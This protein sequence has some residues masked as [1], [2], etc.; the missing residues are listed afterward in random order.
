MSRIFLS[1]RSTDKAWARELK[2]LLE[3]SGHV[4]VFVDDD[5]ETGIPYGQDWERE[6]YR[7]VVNCRAVVILHSKGW[8]ESK[9]CFAE[10]TQARALGKFIIPLRLDDHPLDAL[11]SDTQAIPMT[12]GIAPKFPLLERSLRM[13][14]ID[15][16]DSF[17]WKG[18]RDPYPGLVA[19]E[20]EDA[21]VF[22][23]RDTEI[24]NTL[25]LLSRVRRRGGGALAMVLGASGSGKSSLIRAGVVPR[26]RR[27]TDHWIVTSPFR[28]GRDPMRRLAEVLSATFAQAGEPRQ[29]DVVEAQ[30]RRA[31]PV[32]V[33][34]PAVAEPEAVPA[35]PGAVPPPPP[36][37][38][39]PDPLPPTTPIEP[40]TIES[41]VDLPSP[42]GHDGD[43]LG[44]IADELRHATG[45]TEARLL[46]VV[47][48]FEE[49]LGGDGG[50]H[51]VFLDLL[52]QT[53]D[54]AR[55]ILVV[56]TLRS[57]FLGAFQ[58]ARGIP[59]RY[60]VQLVGPLVDG[61]EEVIR[62]PAVV[63]GVEIEP[64]LVDRIADDT[65]RANAL[66]L[67]A[68][69]L[70]ELWVRCGDDRRLTLDEYVGKIGGIDGAIQRS[71]EEL[72]TDPRVG[73]AGEQQL[74]QAFVSM[75]RRSHEGAW[76]RRVIRRADVP[77]SIVP[78]LEDFE[79]KGL[80]VPDK[81][82]HGAETWEVAHEALFRVRP[83][84]G[85]S[86]LSSRSPRAPARSRP[87][88][89]HAG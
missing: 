23:G 3:A 29:V 30:L 84:R 59:S 61:V 58:N 81:D 42:N 44:R 63:A 85:R 64:A 45:R 35:T 69:T 37:P 34:E 11:L 86:A 1:H 33:P 54:D 60:D 77:A 78:V 62:E 15:P 20:E 49:L 13:A 21:A 28:P 47:D 56:G 48:Q 12:D 71:A 4:G 72:R 9:W 16:A 2:E 27:D 24:R 36:P 65:R 10:L 19:F 83:C 51:D 68:F 79:K 18:N 46:I 43:V 41:E 66:P 25:D 5:P 6:L 26:L 32:L 7:T 75:A 8:S 50:D 17:A 55:G 74:R 87:G 40:M 39:R 70:H 73:E 57:D 52:A 80:I 14:G 53:I 31:A 82:E 76:S 38:P 22:F 67:L 89:P 88:R